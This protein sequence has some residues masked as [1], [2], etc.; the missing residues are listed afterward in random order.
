MPQKEFSTTA[1]PLRVSSVS[2]SL[3]R[4]NTAD[5]LRSTAQLVLILTSRTQT[6]KKS[7]QQLTRTKTC[8]FSLLPK[9][10][11][12]GSAVRRGTKPRRLFP[13]AWRQPT[14]LA[15]KG[16]PG[17]RKWP[18]CNRGFPQRGSRFRGPKLRRKPKRPGSGTSYLEI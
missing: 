3:W 15:L 12:G 2:W 13:A 1:F 6:Q 11:L 16:R 17:I 4:H 18:F 10:T 7:N 5:K 9:W 14:A 8:L